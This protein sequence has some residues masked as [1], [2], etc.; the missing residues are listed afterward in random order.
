MLSDADVPLKGCL[1]GLHLSKVCI[2]VRRHVFISSPHPL[3]VLPIPPHSS[4]Q[5]VRCRISELGPRLPSC[6]QPSGQRVGLLLNEPLPYSS[7]QPNSTDILN[8]DQGNS[9]E[10]IRG[11]NAVIILF[12]PINHRPLTTS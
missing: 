2:K 1:V 9:G 12:F 5:N 4:V 6:T 7:P 3:T 8:N 10:E 11:L